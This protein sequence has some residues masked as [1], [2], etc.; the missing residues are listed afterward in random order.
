MPK[1]DI[2]DRCHFY[3]HS[4]YMVCFIHP[5]GVETEDCEDFC[6]NAYQ[7]GEPLEWWE[8]VGANYYGGELVLDPVQ[9]LTNEQR[10]ELLDSHPLFTGRCPH[11]EMPM[12]QTEPRRVHWDC[13][14]CGWKDDSL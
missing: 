3:S 9:R 12:R 11:C 7:Q 8:P 14:H 2:C 1:L 4:P 6:P 5:N 10:L 13:E